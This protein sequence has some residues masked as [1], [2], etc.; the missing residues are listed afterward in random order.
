MEFK[1]DELIVISTVA[2]PIKLDLGANEISPPGF[3][4]MGRFHGSEIVPLDA[5]DESVDEIR[6]SHVL[7]HFSQHETVAILQ[8]WA[9]KLKPGGTL[10]IAVPNF[11]WIA[12]NYLAGKP[13]NVQGYTMGGQTDANDYHKAIFDDECLAEA[14][15]LAGLIDIRVWPSDIPDCSALDVSLNMMGTKPRKLA[16]D[17]STFKVSAVMS[18]PRLAFMDNFQCAMTALMPM[19]IKLRHHIGAYWEACLERTITAAIEEDQPDAILTIDYD[20]VFGRGDIEKL[21]QTMRERPE[22][23]ALAPMQSARHT[24]QPLLTLDLPLGVKSPERI[25]H[26]VFADDITELRTAHFGLTLIRTSSLAK[27]PRPWLWSQPAP[28]G[29]WGEGRCDADIY[30]W[31]QWREAG[32]KLFSANRVTVGHLELMVLWPG[33]NFTVT[34]QLPRDYHKNGKPKDVWS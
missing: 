8:H 31:K 6:A 10:K 23:D 27:L 13:I 11:Q 1:A 29:T 34:H 15:R 30:F 20:T 5:A 2:M 7:E 22:V 19:G 24:D 16:V 33:Q 12:E 28:D 32:L 21:I 17:G 18:V 26:G 25:A 3:T 9:S 4:P 14:L